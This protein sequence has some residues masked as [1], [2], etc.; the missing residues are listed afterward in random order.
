MTITQLNKL[1]K[2]EIATVEKGIKKYKPEKEFP[3]GLGMYEHLRALKIT[4]ITIKMVRN[5]N[6]SRKQGKPYFVMPGGPRPFVPL[7]QLLNDL[8]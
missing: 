3:I 1:I 7:Q 4:L 8:K 5:T 6:T 2:A